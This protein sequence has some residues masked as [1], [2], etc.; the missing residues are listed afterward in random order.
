M[1]RIRIRPGKPNAVVGAI[2][3][4]IMIG[5]GIF[6]AIPTFGTFGV[7]WTLFAVAITGYNVFMALS[8]SGAER[9]IYVDNGDTGGTFFQPS[10]IRGNNDN[11]A[12]RLG[13]LESLR[14]QNLITEDEYAAK[15]V[16]ILQDL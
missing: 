13:E 6:I 12:S 2:G 10:G 11:V 16:E 7:F 5:I 4:A 14:A 9:E 8:D 3:G 1:A 15:R